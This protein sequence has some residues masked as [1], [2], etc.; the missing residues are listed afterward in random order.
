MFS[1]N[2]HQPVPVRVS[3]S[4]GLDGK[5]ALVVCDREESVQSLVSGLAQ[6]GVDIALACVDEPCQDLAQEEVEAQGRRFLAIRGK[7]NSAAV[8]EQILKVFGQLDLFIDCSTGTKTATKGA[9][10]VNNIAR[11]NGNGTAPH[12]EPPTLFAN[13]ALAK[14][15]LQALT[16]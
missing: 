7:V 11:S 6:R 2:G 13:T 4:N 9:G 1:K 10:V 8:I 15:A 12:A 3:Q 14:A 16:A 5:V